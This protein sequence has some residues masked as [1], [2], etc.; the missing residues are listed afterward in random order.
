MLQS[1]NDAALVVAR[2]VQKSLLVALYFGYTRCTTLMIVAMLCAVALSLPINTFQSVQFPSSPPFQNSPFHPYINHISN[3]I[4]TSNL[5]PHFQSR[6]R[7]LEQLACFSIALYPK[8]KAYTRSKSRRMPESQNAMRANTSELDGA[9]AQMQRPFGFHAGSMIEVYYDTSSIADDG[10]S[11]SKMDKLGSFKAFSFCNASYSIEERVRSERGPHGRPIHSLVISSKDAETH[12]VCFLF[13][14]FEEIELKRTGNPTRQIPCEDK[15]SF[16]LKVEL[17][18]LTEWLKLKPSLRNKKLYDALYD[19]VKNTTELDPVRLRTIW[20]NSRCNDSKLRYQVLCHAAKYAE[21]KVFAQG[22][23]TT[24]LTLLDVFK[25][26]PELKARY[27]EMYDNAIG[28]WLN[29][30]REENNAMKTQ[31]RRE[32]WDEEIER[33]R[34]NREW[35]WEE[36]AR[37]AK[38]V[39]FIKECAGRRGVTTI[40]REDM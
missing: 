37:E 26:V 36:Q 12:A 30:M 17:L 25:T 10:P 38:E 1:S 28:V 6:I 39:A 3:K 31:Q 2:I 9:N 7:E 33:R 5:L 32:W 35:M 22:H 20:L 18:K 8:Y 13:D 29:I 34:E 21:Q 15:W 4:L 16:E 27:E 19:Y 11:A 24:H 23:E 40:R 14:W